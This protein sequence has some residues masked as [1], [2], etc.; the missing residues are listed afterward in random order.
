MDL[1]WF[2]EGLRVELGI[3]LVPRQGNYPP[4]AHMIPPDSETNT[5]TELEEQLRSSE[6]T[7]ANLTLQLKGEV[8][9]TLL[10][11]D[12]PFSTIY[13]PVKVCTTVYRQLST[14]LRE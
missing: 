3:N 4:L 13:W 7:V 5:K 8:R 6:T 12:I 9:K 10:N 11:I 1:F 2:E 14:Q